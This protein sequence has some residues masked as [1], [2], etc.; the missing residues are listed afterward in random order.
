[1]VC[2]GS[3]VVN[4]CVR[5]LLWFEIIFLSYRWPLNN[6]FG[7]DNFFFFSSSSLP[8]DSR[9]KYLCVLNIDLRAHAQSHIHTAHRARTKK[10]RV[11]QI[12]NSWRY[13]N[14]T[15]DIFNMTTWKKYE[16]IILLF[17]EHA[18]EASVCL[19]TSM[20]AAAAAYFFLSFRLLRPFGVVSSVQCKLNIRRMC[21]SFWIIASFSPHEDER[22]LN[23]CGWGQFRNKYFFLLLLLL[24]VCIFYGCVFIW[25]GPA[26]H[27]RATSPAN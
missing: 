8:F 2:N 14:Q 15:I 4:F 25:F 9:Y 7:C 27:C 13:S 3:R 24:W 5:S 12:E 6:G 19:T 20:V 21:K 26:P 11:H 10:K 16:I 1:M 17:D 22:L 18:Y 23:V